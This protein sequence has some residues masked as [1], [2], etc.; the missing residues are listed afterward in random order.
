LRKKIERDPRRPE[1]LLTVYG[2]GYKLMPAPD[3]G[4]G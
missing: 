1:C 2:I 4:Q 3:P